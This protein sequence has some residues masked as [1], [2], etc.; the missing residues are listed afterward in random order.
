MLL[1]TL[2]SSDTGQKA[3]CPTSSPSEKS[4]WQQQNKLL[5]P[6]KNRKNQ[7]ATGRTANTLQSKVR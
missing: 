4:Q 2:R 1:Q 5:A 3:G 7:A 6:D